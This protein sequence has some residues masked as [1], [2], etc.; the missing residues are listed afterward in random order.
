MQGTHDNG[1]MSMKEFN[2]EESQNRLNNHQIQQMV[3]SDPNS[4]IWN[5]NGVGSWLEPTKSIGYSVPS[6][7]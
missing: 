4:L 2:T 3:S 1:G 7:I 6:L 5:A